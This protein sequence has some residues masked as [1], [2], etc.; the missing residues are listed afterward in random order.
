MTV[1]GMGQYKIP[2][3]AQR[4]IS[5]SEININLLAVPMVPLA[6]AGGHALSHRDRE[7]KDG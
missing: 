3:V 1:I 2:P 7:R 6:A 5:V 4:I